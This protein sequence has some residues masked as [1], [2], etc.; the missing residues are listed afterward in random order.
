MPRRPPGRNHV[1]NL[2]PPSRVAQ[3]AER[4]TRMRRRTWMAGAGAALLLAG[5]ATAPKAPAVAPQPP[6]PPPAEAPLPPP[7]PPA[8]PSWDDMALAPGDWRFSSS[9]A[10]R[11]EYGEEGAPAF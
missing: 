5:C 1:R 2:P 9:P 10:P 6:P 4:E 11:A 3:G 8:P 7:P